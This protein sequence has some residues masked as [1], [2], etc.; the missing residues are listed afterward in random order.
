MNYHNKILRLGFKKTK[1]F[2]LEVA[3]NRLVSPEIKFLNGKFY[4]YS[5]WPAI[6]V[7][8]TS[9][10]IQGSFYIMDTGNFICYIVHVKSDLYFSIQIKS[11]NKFICTYSIKDIDDRFWPTILSKIPKDVKREIVINSLIPF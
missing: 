10:K 1:P 7:I 8:Y 9:G 3:F 6:D 2:I 11:K 4:K 5:F